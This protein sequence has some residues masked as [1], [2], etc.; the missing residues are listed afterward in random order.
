MKLIIQK[1]NFCVTKNLKDYQ[2]ES[3]V[4]KILSKYIGYP[5]RPH[6]NELFR[7]KIPQ[8]VIIIYKSN[9]LNKS[10]NSW[11]EIRALST[12]SKKLN[13][14]F[15]HQYKIKDNRGQISEIDGLDL[16]TKI[17]MVEIKRAKIN[18]EWIDYYEKKRLKLNIK[19]C[20]IIAPF[21]DNNLIIP[22]KI[23]LFKFK[24]DFESIIDY[25]NNQFS[26]PIWLSPYVSSRHF[27]I[28]LNNSR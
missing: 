24:T 15:Y 8:G 21:F 7:F 18:Q 10:K 16:I 9:K 13:I 20:Y 11:Y 25:Y 2:Y 12:L 1:K 28:F 27:K 22:N 19:E 14:A 23:N 3:E 5:Q 6:L 26:I 17:K 4:K